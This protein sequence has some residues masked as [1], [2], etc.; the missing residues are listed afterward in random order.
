MYDILLRD[1]ERI[2]TK[3]EKEIKELPFTEKRIELELTL[4]KLKL[5]YH[6]KYNE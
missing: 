4:L 6:T 2:I 1:I 3:L 5:E